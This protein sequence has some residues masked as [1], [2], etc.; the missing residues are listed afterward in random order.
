MFVRTFSV[1]ECGAIWIAKTVPPT[2]CKGSENLEQTQLMQLRISGQIRRP[3]YNSACLLL[4]LILFPVLAV[5]GEP[6]LSGTQR[7]QV[8]RVF[9]AEHP[10]VSRAI[11]RGKAGVRIEGN[12]I[13]PTSEKSEQLIAQYGIVAKPGQRVVVTAVRFTQEGIV[14]EI[15]GGPNKHKKWTDRISLGG[16]LTIPPATTSGNQPGSDP[17]RS[18]SGSFVFFAINKEEVAS[19]TTDRI[20]DLLAPVLDFQSKN[21]AEA[22]QKTLPPRLADAV[23]NHCALVGMNKDM[24]IA[25]LG[26]PPR[27]VRETNEGQYY[28]EWI[29]GT[30]P[31]VVQFIRFVGDKVIR[32]ENMKVSGEK[33]VRTQDEV[34]GLIQ[35]LDV[36]ADKQKRSDVSKRAPTL[37]RPNEKRDSATDT[38][39]LANQSPDY[40]LPSPS[41]SQ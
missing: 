27:R 11:P 36:P 37:L 9:L 26:R 25:A 19:L 29:Y 21:T 3:A 38:V 4:A 39:P 1:P 5:A 35:P 32:I 10:F 30:P 12:K 14:F 16:P 8:I 20:K 34:G 17:D 24:V 41:S 28:E 18:P 2:C 33:E 7:Q 6:K 13:T 40:R 22:Y 23:K 31:K 15:N